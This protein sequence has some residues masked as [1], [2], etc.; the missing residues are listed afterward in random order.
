MEN[1]DKSQENNEKKPII[2]NL[3]DTIHYSSEEQLNAFLDNMNDDQAIYCIKQ[4]LNYCHLSSMF[5]LIE[6]EAI[7][8]SLRVLFTK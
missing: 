2:G 5:S 1:T 6:S 4:A 3:F 8:K 7:S